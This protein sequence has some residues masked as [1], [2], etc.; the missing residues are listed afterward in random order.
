MKGKLIIFNIIFLLFVTSIFAQVKKK[1]SSTK[2][3][4]LSLCQLT[5]APS[6]RGFFL[7]QTVDEFNKIIPNF[8]KA[9]EIEKERSSV[10][11]LTDYSADLTEGKEMGLVQFG[12]NYPFPY[13]S[14]EPLKFSKDEDVNHFEW[15]FYKEK[16]YAFSIYYEDYDPPSAQ[17]FA[18]QVAE[19]L[20]LPLSGWKKLETPNIDSPQNRASRVMMTDVEAE[21]KCNGFKVFV[22]T[23]YRNF[24]NLTITNTNVEAEILKL[25]KEIKQRKKREEQ[26]RIRLEREK[27][28]VFKP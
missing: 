22:H 24:A 1:S 21:L 3:Q 12:S 14:G 15:F 23:A 28:E 5:E 16:L 10:F 2:K 4:V 20:N 27:K 6:L 18:K 7:G 25:E 11:S 8:K 9:Y 19:K 26:E 13:D 17:V